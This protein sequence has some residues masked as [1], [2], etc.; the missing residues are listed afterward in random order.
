M[1]NV[2]YYEG[3]RIYFRP[4]E[5]A[6]EPALRVWVNDP[7][8]WRTLGRFLP[9][10]AQRERE[11]LEAA[12]ASPE[13]LP[14]GVALRDKHELIGC[15]GLHGIDAVSR[16]ATLGILIGDV[17]HQGAGYGSEAIRLMVRYAF[18]VLNL[19]R[20]GLSVYAN[21]PR[22]IRVYEKS[23]FVREGRARQAVWREGAY[24]DELY[25]AILRQDYETDRRDAAGETVR[26]A[27]MTT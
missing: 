11:W 25:Y 17:R 2:K 3:E 15:I 13:N 5:L 9:V 23:G 26:L 10:N 14:F 7:R 22:A 21:N 1:A 19:N 27:S 12:Y 18:E 24:H 8:N 20:V 6:D 4:L 16:R